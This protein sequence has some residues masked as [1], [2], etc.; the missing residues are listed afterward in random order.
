MIWARDWI[1]RR[2]IVLGVARSILVLIGIADTD[3]V[4]TSV[5]TVASQVA[6]FTVKTLHKTA[7]TTIDTGLIS[8]LH[9]IC[10]ETR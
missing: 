3:Q 5:F 6:G 4:A 8:T 9:A 1:L 10:A 7:T 2:T